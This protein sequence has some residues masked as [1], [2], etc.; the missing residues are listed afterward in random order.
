MAGVDHARASRAAGRRVRQTARNAARTAV[1]GGGLQVRLTTVG[2]VAI[3]VT[4]AFETHHGTR[5]RAARTARA[6][7]GALAALTRQ[8]LGAIAPP[9]AIH[10]RLGSVLHRVGAGRNGTA[11]FSA[12]KARAVHVR[13]AEEAI[14]TGPTPAAAVHIRLT[15]VTR[16]IRAVTRPHAAIGEVVQE[17][18]VRHRARGTANEREHRTKR[19]NDRRR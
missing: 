9:A 4:F 6:V 14:R 3:A 19:K 13:G 2:H 8:A 15:F 1:L 11:T 10:V 17:L 12:D 5:A 18:V 16:L 7:V